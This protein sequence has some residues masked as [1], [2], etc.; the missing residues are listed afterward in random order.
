M[1]PNRVYFADFR[2]V[3]DSVSY[4]AYFVDGEMPL[5]EASFKITYLSVIISIGGTPRKSQ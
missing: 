3:T 2:H 4:D 1:K 5:L